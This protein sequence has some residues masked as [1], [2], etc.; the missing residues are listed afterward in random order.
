MPSFDKEMA[1]FIHK[2][3]ILNNVS[4]ILGDPVNSFGKTEN[5]TFFVKT[6]SG[7]KIE[8]ELFILSIGIQPQSKLA[9]DSGLDVSRQDYIIVDKNMLTS[10]PNIYAVGDVVQVSQLQIMEPI[11][12]ALAGPAN[13]QG[14]IAADNIAGRNVEYK[15]IIGASVVK[16]FDVTVASV[17]LS[18]KM[19]KKTN[20][21]YEKVYIHPDNHASYYPGA[22]PLTIKLIFEIPSGKVLGTQIVGG[23]GVEKRVD[24]ISTIIKL[25]GTVFDLEEL[26]L[27]YAPPYGS[28]KDPVN[29]AGFVAANYLRRDI[30]LIQWHEIH[31]FSN[32][33]GIILD[34]R[35][36]REHEAR[37][38]D[39]SL[40]IPINEIRTRLMELSKDKPIVVYCEVGYR[41]YLASRI[42]MQNG[43]NEVYE[44][45]GGFKLFETAY[46]KIEDFG[47]RSK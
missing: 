38:I 5:N 19:L 15:G 41:S 26:E 3:L 4:L 20:I 13:K 37:R 44:L 46:A 33:N 42:L 24:V 27:T 30:A 14:R 11:A 25:N 8:T 32:E 43:F 17:G 40:N 10:D 21:K 47:K 2:E 9:K 7:R 45:T 23:S 18:E 28:A 29:M 31:E 22:T 39:G 12:I 35:S 36:K 1:Q 34:V 16:V 6:R